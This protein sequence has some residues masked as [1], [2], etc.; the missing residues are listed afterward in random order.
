MHRQKWSA[1]SRI[2]FIHV[3]SQAMLK[4]T[5]SI[6]GNS[7]CM[8]QTEKSA[9][10][11]SCRKFQ[12]IFNMDVSGRAF[13]QSAY[14]QTSNNMQVAVTL[15]WGVNNMHPAEQSMGPGITLQIHTQINTQFL[16]S[17]SIFTKKTFITQ[18]LLNIKPKF[19]ESYLSKTNFHCA[20]LKRNKVI[21]VVARLTLSFRVW[22]VHTSGCIFLSVL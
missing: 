19:V 12:L 22:T 4:F 20:T 5:E 13:P 21:F 1:I 17:L 2:Q 10:Y 18:L 14:C 3:K 11:D 15:G 16:C 7:N 9:H 6:M 8:R